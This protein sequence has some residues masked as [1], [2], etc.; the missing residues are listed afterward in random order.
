[1]GL[2]HL[3]II[4][5][6][7]GALKLNSGRIWTLDGNGKYNGHDCGTGLCENSSD[8]HQAFLFT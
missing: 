8:R 6:S 5:N 4:A 1:M 2:Y 3:D 7:M